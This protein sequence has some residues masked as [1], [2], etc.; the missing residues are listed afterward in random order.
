[1]K[2]NEQPNKGGGLG[3]KS[4]LPRNRFYLKVDLESDTPKIKKIKE[5]L[6]PLLKKATEFIESVG[7]IN[8]SGIQLSDN[9]IDYNE[10]GDLDGELYNNSSKEIQ[11]FVRRIVRLI[12]IG[13]F[14]QVSNYYLNTT[15]VLPKQ[16]VPIV[17]KKY[18]PEDMETIVKILQPAIDQHE[19]NLKE[20][21]AKRNEEKTSTPEP[22]KSS[23][24]YGSN[25][26]SNYSSNNSRYTSEGYSSPYTESSEVNSSRYNT[27]DFLGDVADYGG[28]AIDV[29][30]II[31]GILSI[32]GD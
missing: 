15:F 11:K 20:K 13:K 9:N 6:R 24:N 1:M 16:D 5:S 28:A 4:T 21:W 25:R 23:R 26:S 14:E 3:K 32:F 29:A 30:D 19:A 12:E 18:T 22:K 2:S 7:S 31:G 17:A 10:Y 8:V 27:N